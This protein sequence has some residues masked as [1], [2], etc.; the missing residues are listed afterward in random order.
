M[1]RFCFATM[2]LCRFVTTG[3]A[4]LLLTAAPAYAQGT[5]IVQPQQVPYLEL[6]V[7]GTLAGLVVFVVCRS[8][9]RN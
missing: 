1:R 8:S 9:R 6:L 4:V 3:A 5:T 2:P 7:T